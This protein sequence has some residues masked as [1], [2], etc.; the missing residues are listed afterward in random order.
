MQSIASSRSGA[1]FKDLETFE[2]K[3][4][5]SLQYAKTLREVCE[6]QLGIPQDVVASEPMSQ[7][8]RNSIALYE[9]VAREGD[10]LECVS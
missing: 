4:S 8:L 7:Q 5:N 9:R 6:K 3:K 2:G 1:T 10:W